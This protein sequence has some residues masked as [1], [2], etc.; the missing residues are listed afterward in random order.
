MYMLLM[1]LIKSELLQGK[2]HRQS[3][4]LLEELSGGSTCEKCEEFGI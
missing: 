4:A 1:K 2:N 3:V